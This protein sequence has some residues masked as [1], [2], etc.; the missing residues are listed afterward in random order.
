[1]V[2]DISTGLSTTVCSMHWDDMDASVVCRSLGI[3]SS[4]RA[5]Y[6]TRDPKYD[7]GIFGTYCNGSESHL[8]DCSIDDYDTSYGA[9]THFPDA[10]VECYT[11]KHFW[12]GYQ[13]SIQKTGYQ[14]MKATVQNLIENS[15]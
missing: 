5:T 8:G 4:G 6:I 14:Q 9:C 2:M 7:R 3:S 13:F 1:M 12:E 10:G 15:D 11:G